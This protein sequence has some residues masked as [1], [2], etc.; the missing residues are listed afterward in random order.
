MCIWIFFG[1]IHFHTQT[2]R[3][4]YISWGICDHFVGK[5]NNLWSIHFGKSNKFPYESPWTYCWS[6]AVC[7]S[8]DLWPQETPLIFYEILKSAI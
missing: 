6:S 5:C 2:H 1:E 3:V 7:V 8:H 4:F